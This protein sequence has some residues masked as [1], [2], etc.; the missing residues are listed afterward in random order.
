M[1]YNSHFTTTVSW[2]QSGSFSKLGVKVKNPTK[3][4]SFAA[5]TA[6]HLLFTEWIRLDTVRIGMFSHSWSSAASNSCKE[7][8]CTRRLRTRLTCSSQSCSM[9]GKS[10]DTAGHFMTSMLLFASNCRVTLG[11]CGVNTCPMYCPR[12]RRPCSRRRFRTVWSAIGRW[13]VP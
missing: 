3:W 5:R 11:V 7:C 10:G 12:S 8:G 1:T 9:G 2:V 13:W 6:A 4:T